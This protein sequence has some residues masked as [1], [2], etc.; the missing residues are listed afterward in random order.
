MKNCRQTLNGIVTQK[1]QGL[2][3]FFPGGSD[4]K[5]SAC[6]AGDPGSIPGL[7][8][9]PGE[10]NGYPLQ[11]S[12]LENPKD[13]GAWWTTVHGV[14]E[15]DRTERLHSHLLSGFAAFLLTM[16]LRI[17]NDCCGLGL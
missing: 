11:H 16:V 9:S 14:A 4:G 6:N 10:G 12:C 8:K 7:G 17:C 2:P 1:S 3:P 5:E 15:S 13:R